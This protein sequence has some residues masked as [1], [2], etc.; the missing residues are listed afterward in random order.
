MAVKRTYL[1]TQWLCKE[2]YTYTRPSAGAALDQIPGRL[3][4]KD[5]SHPSNLQKAT[6]YVQDPRYVQVGCGSMHISATLHSRDPKIRRLALHSLSTV[7]ERRNEELLFE[8]ATRV[9]N[10]SILSPD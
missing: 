3:L 2:S 1:I 6:L 5:V 8:D 7:G 4:S 10:S 9:S